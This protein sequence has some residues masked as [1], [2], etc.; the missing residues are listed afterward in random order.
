MAIPDYQLAQGYTETL[1]N[2]SVDRVLAVSQS[3]GWI[4]R[5]VQIALNSYALATVLQYPDRGFLNLTYDQGSNVL[6]NR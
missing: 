2:T 3:D 1:V 5:K 4:I 6:M